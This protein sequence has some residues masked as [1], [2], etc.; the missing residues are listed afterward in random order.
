[1]ILDE[2][3]AALDM[4]SEFYVKEALKTIRLGRTTVII[5][6]RLSAI[7]N[8]DEIVV[9]EYGK[10]AEQGTHDLLMLES[11][12]YAGLHEQTASI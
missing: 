8:A 2:P 10:V 4:E 12:V 3:T 1:M 11:G 7:Q 5:A 9:L 6:H